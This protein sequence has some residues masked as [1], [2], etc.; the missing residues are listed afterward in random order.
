MLKDF[1]QE[2]A[3]ETETAI[4]SRLC[5]LCFLLFEALEMTDKLAA[6]HQLTRNLILVSDQTA[7]EKSGGRK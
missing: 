5:S 3:E 2:S 7:H 1:E 4:E 6:K